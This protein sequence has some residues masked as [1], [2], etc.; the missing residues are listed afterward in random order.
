[1]KTEKELLSIAE[2]RIVNHIEKNK[3]QLQSHISRLKKVCGKNQI[4][5]SPIVAECRG[6]ADGRDM[7]W[8]KV[9]IDSFEF[10]KSILMQNNII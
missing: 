7:L 4:W 6:V 2:K 9:D 3:S 1:M 10:T 8:C 5:F